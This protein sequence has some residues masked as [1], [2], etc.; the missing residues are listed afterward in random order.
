[1]GVERLPVGEGFIDGEADRVGHRAD[2]LEPEAAGLGPGQAD[3]L[4]Q[5]GGDA[6]ALFQAAADE[7]PGKGDPWHGRQVRA[8]G[9]VREAGISGCVHAW[10]NG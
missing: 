1:M 6:V 4:G 9:A 2:D 3:M 8:G 10:T 7:E 5:Q